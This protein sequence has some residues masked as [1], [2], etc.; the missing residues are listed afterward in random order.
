MEARKI[1]IVSTKTQSK[2]V[3]MSSA[4]TLG[5]LKNDLRANDIDYHDMTFYEGLSKVELKDD[6]AIL[7]HDIPYRGTVTNELVFMLTNPTTKIKSGADRYTLYSTIKENGLKGKCLE[8]Y[9][10]NYTNC[11]TAQLENLISKYVQEETMPEDKVEEINEVSLDSLLDS[12]NAL[13]D[14]INTFEIAL[15]EIGGVVD[16][17]KEDCITSCSCKEMKSS[18]TDKEIDDM[19]RNIL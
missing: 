10:K 6:N 14:A 11:S 15:N 18:Y 5:D 12:L 1:T 2:S 4:T 3:I 7:P 16:S 8:E 19:F 13:K 9:G 17:H